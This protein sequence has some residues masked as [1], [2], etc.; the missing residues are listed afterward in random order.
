MNASEHR[1]MT[2]PASTCPTRLCLTITLNTHHIVNAKNGL[3]LSLLNFDFGVLGLAGV[4]LVDLLSLA[5]YDLN[6]PSHVAVG[7]E[8]VP[9]SVN[10]VVIGKCQLVEWQ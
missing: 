9:A 5:T 2:L 1:E 7:L 4:E 10:A 6:G 3:D 8:L